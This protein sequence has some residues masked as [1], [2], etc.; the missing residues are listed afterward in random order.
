MSAKRP[1]SARQGHRRPAHRPF[2]RHLRSNSPGTSGSR[3]SRHAAF[4]LDR[5]FFIPSGHPPH[6]PLGELPAFRAS[7]R[8]GCAGLRRQSALCSFARRMCRRSRP[9]G[10]LFGRYRAPFPEE[11]DGAGRSHLTSSW[12]PTRSCRSRRG[13]ITRRC[14]AFAISSWPAGPGFAPTRCGK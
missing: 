8:H 3:A 7:L 10:V 13:R 5:V 1:S 12:A 2:R 6:K 4:H 9:D 14:W 11:Y